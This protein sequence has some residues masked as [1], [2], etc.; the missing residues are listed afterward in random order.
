VNGEDQCSFGCNKIFFERNEENNY[1]LRK[2]RKGKKTKKILRSR[3]SV[4]GLDPPS[5]FGKHPRR[6]LPLTAPPP[7]GGG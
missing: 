7:Y 6:R 4:K 5:F 3:R 1:E 2:E